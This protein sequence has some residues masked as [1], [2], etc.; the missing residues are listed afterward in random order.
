MG[1]RFGMNF[2][3]LTTDGS[4]NVDDGLVS[5]DVEDDHFFHVEVIWL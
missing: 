5:A 4:S 3:D 2:S 1:Q